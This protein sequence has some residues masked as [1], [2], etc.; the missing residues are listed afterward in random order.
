MRIV[1][2]IALLLSFTLVPGATPSC[3]LV[4]DVPELRATSDDGGD[5]DRA[6][7][8]A[9]YDAGAE[10]DDVRDTLDRAGDVADDAP[11]ETDAGEDV[12]P[13]LCPDGMVF[14]AA[15][16]FVRGSDESEGEDDEHP[17]HEVFLDA[18]CIDRLEVTHAAYE[19]CRA[20]SA[21]SP[22]ACP[23]GFDGYPV[24]CVNWLRANAYCTWAGKRLP[25]EAEWEKAARGGC[26]RHLPPDCGFEDERIYP[27]GNEEPSCDRAN[28]STC[29][30]STAAVGTHPAGAGPYGTEDQAGNV[31][32]WTADWY[33]AAA[34]Q[35]C[36]GGCANPTGP[37]G[38]TWRVVRGGGF[39]IGA[40]GVR[41]A[42]R[43]ALDPTAEGESVGFRCA[44]AP[45]EP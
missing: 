2:R 42:D 35:T 27:W 5:S 40:F 13:G 3:T 19:A 33:D 17:E 37:A 9:P 30:S 29:G 43:F 24:N 20:A 21:C 11:A 8:D 15:G 4:L 36:A 45:A 14:V 22:P 23:R 1:R 18:F 28:F 26:E 41:V 31:A 34:Y 16:P 38:G 25:T 32:E 10:S 39:G 12:P 44:C 6:D 7:E